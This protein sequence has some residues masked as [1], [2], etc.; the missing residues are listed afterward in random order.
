MIRINLLPIKD[1][2]RAMGRRQQLSLVLLGLALAVLVMIIPYVLQ[3]HKLNGLDQ[4]IDQLKAELAKL[5]Q[6]TREVRELDK[7]RAELQ[8]KLKVIEDL[9]QKRVGPV[10]IL[11][12]LSAATPEKL[13]LVEFSD[14]NGAATITGMALDNQTIAV[15]MRQLQN[16]KYFFEV[17]LVETSQ[18]EPLRGGGAGDG[19]SFKKFIIKAHLDYLGVGGKPPGTPSASPPAASKTGA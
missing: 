3:A 2:Q 17:D 6:Q 11:E 15:F 7:R 16:S 8:G 12:D 1:A 14:V 4:G 9:K 5:E 19:A 13:W 10:R 18:T